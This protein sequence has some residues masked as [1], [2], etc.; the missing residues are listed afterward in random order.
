MVSRRLV[1]ILCVAIIEN[2]LLRLLLKLLLLGLFLGGSL[3]LFL[4][5]IDILERRDASLTLHW[6][7]R[8]LISLVIFL[9]VIALRFILALLS[10]HLVVLLRRQVLGDLDDRA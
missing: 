10:L 5:L 9:V 8:I 2:L 1:C 6:R 4:I 3:R 7:C